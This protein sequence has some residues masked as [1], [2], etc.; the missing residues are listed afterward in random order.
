MPK[1]PQTPRSQARVRP[2]KTFVDRQLQRLPWLDQS[3]IEA[4]LAAEEAGDSDSGD[5]ERNQKHHSPRRSRRS[6]SNARLESIQEK[7]LQVLGVCPVGGVSEES[8]YIKLLRRLDLL[9]FRIHLGV[10][11]ALERDLPPRFPR[12]RAWV[13][14]LWFEVAV[15]VLI[16]LNSV[17][18][19][20]G[21]YYEDD[22]DVRPLMLIIS[23]HFFIVVFLVEFMLR[24]LA[25]G[26]FW[27]FSPPNVLDSLLIW[28]T[29]VLSRWILAPCGIDTGL[30]DSMS[31]LRIFRLFRLCR[32]LRMLP[33]FRELW[34]LVKGITQCI[35]LLFW[36]L[37]L[38]FAVQYVFAVAVIDTVSKSQEFAE[39]DEVQR[40]FGS[41]STAMFT[42]FRLM[43][44]D[45][46]GAVV[47]PIVY[48]SPES[49]VLFLTFLGVAGIVLFNLMTA[50]VVKNAFDAQQEDDEMVAQRKALEFAQQMNDLARMFQETAHVGKLTKAE[51]FE[52]LDD[53][54]FL[55]RMRILDIEVQELP[56]IFEMYDEGVGQVNTNDFV[57]GLVRMRGVA[58]SRDILKATS[59]VLRVS[60][61][62]QSLLEDIQEEQLKELEF[63]QERISHADSNL[64][65][66][67]EVTRQILNKLDEIG[68]QKIFKATAEQFPLVVEPTL[69]QV[70]ERDRIIEDRMTDLRGR[71]R[72]N[73]PAKPVATSKAL[74]VRAVPETWICARK[75]ERR[76]RAAQWSQK[77]NGKVARVPAS[78]A[79]M[80]PSAER[81]VAQEFRETWNDIGF[82]TSEPDFLRAVA[83]ATPISA[84]SALSTVDMLPAGLLSHHTGEFAKATHRQ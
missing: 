3:E 65:E 36:T 71:R 82:A 80:K 37:F 41:L 47:R 15:G 75:E 21:T 74:R 33:Q 54:N 9:E 39:D 49:C 63:V 1:K 11:V 48:R 78:P 60:N 58:M 56:E 18:L 16:I 61:K 25:Y 46:W 34:T 6:A 13:E 43:T 31:A 2:I 68:I 28:V 73:L 29:G 17:F 83:N 69:E 26:F 35:S 19:G 7:V 8:A 70:L 27:I 10:S 42:G 81:G 50:I 57:V 53:A 79:A 52:C 76:S 20:L 30:L 64:Y 22:N 32:A 5:D 4:K 67:Q 12:I 44:F 72:V 38:T 55:R 24:I 40:L 14:T 59:I 45:N 77:V 84:T 66:M 62:Y 23:E 51:F